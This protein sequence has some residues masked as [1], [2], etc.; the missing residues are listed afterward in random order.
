[1]DNLNST[2][3]ATRRRGRRLP[4]SH[5]PQ[6]ICSVATDSDVQL[7]HEMSEHLGG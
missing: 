1:M 6:N 3:P 2:K 7:V 5:N 4:I